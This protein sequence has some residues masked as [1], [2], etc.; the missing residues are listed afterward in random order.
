M[1]NTISAKQVD[2]CLILCRTE[3]EIFIFSN[4]FLI[5]IFTLLISI[6][7]VYSSSE[8]DS[9]VLSEIEF[10]TP[11]NQLIAGDTIFIVIKIHNQDGS[12]ISGPYWFNNVVYQDTLGNGGK[13]DPIVVVDS[14]IDTINELPLTTHSARECFNDGIDTIKIVLYNAP[15][16]N[17]HKLFIHL[18]N[19]FVA[20]TVP[21]YLYPGKIDSLDIPNA[22]GSSVPDTV[23][24][25]APDDSRMF[26][27]AG[28]DHY[29]NRIPGWTLCNWS[30]SGNLPPVNGQNVGQIY[31]ETKSVISNVSGDLTA[32]S[33]D[34]SAPLYVKDHV[35]I[36]II[37]PAT[38]IKITSGDSARDSIETS[39]GS[40]GCGCGT[41]AGL[42]FIPTIF[43][44]SRYRIK[45]YLKRH[46]NT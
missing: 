16:N 41:G 21:F 42:A 45:K 25:N 1:R 34:P 33:A 44:K 31:Y 26:Y 8:S 17:V 46:K 40:N 4:R 14:G 37:V 32:A 7:Y 15:F 19:M 35:F 23:L 22:D 18:D 39:P 6:H 12:Q 29:G 11:K 13:P 5:C 36:K 38:S 27:A 20:S 10:L 9:P 28:F 24:L 30:V 43:M 2:L 3:R